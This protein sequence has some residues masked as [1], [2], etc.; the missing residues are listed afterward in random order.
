MRQCHH[1]VHSW[2]GQTPT[3]RIR[4]HVRTSSHDLQNLQT[5]E[6]RYVTKVLGAE[7]VYVISHSVG[8]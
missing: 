6:Y 7:V 5:V 4:N 2:L 3:K 8:Y 1:E